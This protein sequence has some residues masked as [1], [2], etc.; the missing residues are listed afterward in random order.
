MSLARANYG[1]FDPTL[2]RS[3]CPEAA[4][5]QGRAQRSRG[6]ALAGLMSICLGMFAWV[7]SAADLNFAAQAQRGFWEALKRY[8]AEPHNGQAAW[9]FGRVCFDR[10]EFATN[11]TERG[12]IANLGIAACEQLIAREPKSAPAHYYLSLNLGQLAQTKGLGAL[13][14]VDQM[15]REFSIVRDLDH[16]FDYAGADRGLGLLYRDAPPIA[17]IGSR[18]KARHHLQC[19][20]ELAP[21]YPENG[22]N[23]IEAYLKWSDRNGARRELK[24][25]EES[26]DGA[27]KTFAGEKW[28]MSW[29]DWEK[30]LKQVKKKIEDAPKALESPRNKE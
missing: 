22:L 1:V 21:E 3:K 28:A 2:R 24:A 12:E 9:E 16:K 11:S 7:S 10:A 17:S 13:K 30:R 4:R 25:L 14:I 6:V 18:S 19:A 20:K 26:W 23:L 15:E 27:R 5:K 29:I 8:E